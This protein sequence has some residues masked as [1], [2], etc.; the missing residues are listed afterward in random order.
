MPSE[1]AACQLRSLLS[2]RSHA[3]GIEKAHPVAGF[4]QRD[5]VAFFLTLDSVAC[6]IGTTE[7][8]DRRVEEVAFPWLG[9]GC[10]VVRSLLRKNPD[11]SEH[12]REQPATRSDQLSIENVPIPMR[13]R[14]LA[15]PDWEKISRYSHPGS[16]SPSPTGQQRNTF[17]GEATL[18]C[19]PSCATR[20]S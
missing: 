6:A 12:Q 8:P 14:I 3:S 19:L 11:V 2:R 9:A 4:A 1:E 5:G 18:C 10:R 17:S 20:L 15:N 16:Q 7:Q 13:F